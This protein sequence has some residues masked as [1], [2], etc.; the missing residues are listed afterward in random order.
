MRLSSACPQFAGCET[1]EME[2][3]V[4]ARGEMS[5]V[6]ADRFATAGD[7]GLQSFHFAGRA[8]EEM[9]EHSPSTVIVGGADGA[10]TGNRFAA[11]T[12]PVL[13]LP[14][15]SSPESR[16]QAEARE[17]LQPRRQR[18]GEPFTFC[19][20]LDAHASPPRSLAYNLDILSQLPDGLFAAKPCGALTDYVKS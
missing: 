16:L 5:A 10:Q 3:G 11:Q 17:G 14:Q 2:P 13:T 12:V 7:G 15:T 6:A 9:V 20:P 19:P 1:E 8:M 4:P 18:R